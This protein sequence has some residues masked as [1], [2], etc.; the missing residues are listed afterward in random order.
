MKPE[1]LVG[2]AMFCIATGAAADRETLSFGTEAPTAER[3]QEFLFPEAECENAKYQCLAVRPVTERSIG[4]QILCYT[5]SADLTSAAVKQ[6]EGLGKVLASRRGK[7]TPAEIIV[8]GHTDARGSIE[9]NRK[10]SE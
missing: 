7:L 8:E 9:F 3:V 2:L 1:V 10:L 5:G 4:V 6:L